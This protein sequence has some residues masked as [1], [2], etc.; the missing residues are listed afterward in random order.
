VQERK[1]PYHSVVTL[2]LRPP[3]KTL[4]ILLEDLRTFTYHLSGQSW[5]NVNILVSAIKFSKRKM[6]K[7]SNY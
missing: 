2:L 3:S 6:Q 7:K 1:A 4:T 5:L